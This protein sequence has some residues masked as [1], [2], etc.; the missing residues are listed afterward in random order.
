MVPEFPDSDGADLGRQAREWFAKEWRGRSF[1]AIG[2]QDPV[3]GPAVM[4][5]VRRHIRACPPPFEVADG[6]H[7]LQEWG[8]PVAHAAL[9]HFG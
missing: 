9:A 3:L 4:A 8:E 2:M 1:M 5:G 6:G 7:F